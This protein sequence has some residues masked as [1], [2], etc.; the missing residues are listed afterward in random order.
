MRPARILLIAVFGTQ[1]IATLIAVYVHGATRLEV[2]SLRLG[3]RPDLV[4]P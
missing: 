4:P 2:G 1:A 3:M